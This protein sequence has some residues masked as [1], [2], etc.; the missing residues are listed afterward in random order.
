MKKKNR[1]ISSKFDQIL[2]K[3]LKKWV[4]AD[5]KYEKKIFK[6]YQNLGKDLTRIAKKRRKLIENNEIKWWKKGENWP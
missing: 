6:N 5:Q 3:K 2:Q 4:G 1:W